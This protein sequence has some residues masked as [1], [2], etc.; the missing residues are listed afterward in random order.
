MPP[1]RVL[2]EKRVGGSA[3]TALGRKDETVSTFETGRG[4][5]GGRGRPEDLAER[6]RLEAEQ[7]CETRVSQ[8]K[9]G[10]KGIAEKGPWPK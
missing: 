8:P 9:T 10:G 2:R 4:G 7:C 3:L 5:W 1:E 6:T